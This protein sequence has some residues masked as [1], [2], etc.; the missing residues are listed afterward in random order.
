[1]SI[2]EIYG[3]SQQWV[4]K[5]VLASNSQE[6]VA[7]AQH[8]A[9]RRADG[10][11]AAYELDAHQCCFST[12]HTRHHLQAQ[13]CVNKPSRWQPF[14]TCASQRAPRRARLALGRRAHSR[15]S[16]QSGAAL[17][18]PPEMHAAH[19]AGCVQQGHQSL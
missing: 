17:S 18:S 15:W 5:D 1:M 7:R 19:V 9:E 12:H 16:Q 13:T 2:W 14:C 3:G 11:R 4:L 6:R 10:V 8:R